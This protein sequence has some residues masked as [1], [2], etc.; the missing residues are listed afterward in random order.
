MSNP[1][2]QLNYPTQISETAASRAPAFRLTRYFSITSLIGL[3][4]VTACLIGVYRELTLRNLVEHESRANVDLTRAF[5]NHVWSHFR[6]FVL[7]SNGRSRES[8]IADPIQQQLRAEV[9][10]TMRGL[11]VVK[12]KI[13]N[14]DG[15]TVFSTDPAQIGEDRR[16]N[17]GFMKALEGQA[18]SSVTHRDTFDAFEG[19]ISKRD[20]VFSYIPVRNEATQVT[21]AVFEVYSDVTEMLATQRWAQWQVA[22]V[23][24]VL[25]VALYLFLWLVVRKADGIIAA[26][27]AM[28]AAKEAEI[29]HQAHH[30]ALTGLANR[31][32]FIERLGESL[33]EARHSQ[34]TGALLFIDLDRFKMVN[35]S[36]GHAAGD[37]L[38]KTVANRIR[39]CL[40]QSD[41]LFRLGGDEFT[42]IAMEIPAAE[43][44]ALLARRIIASVSAPITLY[45]NDVSVGASIGIAL[46]PGDGEAPEQLVKN[47]DAAMYNAKQRCRGTHAYYQTAMNELAMH[48]L[49]LE[50][51]LKQA[52]R[53]GELVLYYQPLVDAATRRIVAVEGLLRWNSPTRGLVQPASFITVLEEADMMQLI[54]EWVLRSA[55]LQ[56][57]QWEA[58]GLQPIR[59]SVNVSARQFQSAEFPGIVARVL[60]ETGVD[61]SVIELELTESLLITNPEQARE[62][63]AALKG[64]GVRTSIDDFGTGYSSLSYLREFAVDCLKV[65]RSFVRDV[66]ENPR[67][68]AVAMAIIQLARALGISVVAEGVETEAQAAFFTDAGCAEL[69][70]YLFSRPLP[71]AQLRRLLPGL[72][73]PPAAAAPQTGFRQASHAL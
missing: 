12:I 7:N 50:S 64:L 69:Q 58:E 41:L 43:S 38:L 22:G 30:D 14:L 18:I 17:A 57:R 26:Q 53:E 23:L 1:D 31:T 11:K 52:F 46:F 49:S 35:D 47:A 51:D 13:Y 62:T 10:D 44:A 45:G 42:V 4:V 25:Q 21:E 28:Q 72:Q 33:T 56:Q 67:D 73:D 3:L 8:L 37:M 39:G 27:T 36:L 40:R 29:R 16:K 20:L 66:A 71:V 48:R 60:N 65:D 32:Y 34:R 55:C 61:P 70:G 54:G 68:A 59:V 63:F 24:L 2:L 15:L 19:Q 9:V 6:E 5:S